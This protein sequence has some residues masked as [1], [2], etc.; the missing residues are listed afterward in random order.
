[1]TDRLTPKQC[2]RIMGVTVPFLNYQMDV[3]NWDLGL[4]GKS[5]S[6]RRT[7]VIF[8]AKVEQHLGRMLTEEEMKGE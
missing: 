2:A 4:V 8:R 6:G 3:G 1:M 7:H 5:K